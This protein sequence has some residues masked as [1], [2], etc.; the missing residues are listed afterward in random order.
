MFYPRRT[1]LSPDGAEGGGAEVS[2][3]PT[4]TQTAAEGAGAEGHAQSQSTP[5]AAQPKAV[6]DA[7]L[8]RLHEVERRMKSHDDFYR[9]LNELGFKKPDEALSALGTHQKLQGDPQTA[10]ILEMLA[11]PPQE[12]QETQTQTPLTADSIRDV[13]MDVLTQRDNQHLQ[14]EL[15][16]QTEQEQSLIAD[17]LRSDR[18]KPLFGDTPFDEAFAGTAKDN[19]LLKKG[20][21]RLLDAAMYEKAPRQ[22]DRMLPIT[23]PALM[24]AAVDDV[25]SIVNAVKAATIMELSQTGMLKEE[26][27]Q[28]G[29]RIQEGEPATTGDLEAETR[30][31]AHERVRAMY[32]QV[33]A[34]GLPA[35][36]Q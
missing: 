30:K 7:E 27:G 18:L 33:E 10:A 19:P 8:S 2:A 13:V 9:Q 16:K 5:P 20:I 34:G 32:R 35:S 26:D 3:T 31:R 36:Q 28:I 29:E 1:L 4:P 22:G 25:F 6:S 23:D 15:Q 14:Q 21:A 24:N 11:N 12:T 17:T